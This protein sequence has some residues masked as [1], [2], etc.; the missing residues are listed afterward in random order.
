MGPK[1]QWAD[2]SMNASNLKSDAWCRD[3]AN[4]HPPAYV[5]PAHWAPLGIIQYTGT[6][7]PYTGDLLIPAHGSWNRQPSTGRVLA[8]A[9]LENDAVTDFTII[10]GQKNANGQLVQG[11]A[12]DVRP[13]DVRQGPD[14]ALSSAMTIRARC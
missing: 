14:E 2:E 7:L 9:K 4:V 8:H 12:W 13:V 6:A 5:M 10:V 11:D 3:T 1:T